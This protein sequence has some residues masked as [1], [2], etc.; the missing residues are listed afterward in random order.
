M[1]NAGSEFS[2]R[3]RVAL[4]TIRIHQRYGLARTF[5]RSVA[6]V[7]AVYLCRDIFFSLA[8]KDTYLALS[9]A[10]LSDIKILASFSMAGLS[11]LWALRERTLRHRTNKVFGNQN[12][13]KAN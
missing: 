1:A 3:D 9:V 10:F 11:T 13:P 7:A 2:K 6:V 5:V 12:R 4:E 8:G